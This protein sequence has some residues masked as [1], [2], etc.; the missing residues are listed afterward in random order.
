VEAGIVTDN[1]VG[2]NGEPIAGETLYNHGLVDLLEHAIGQVK[3]GEV[4]GIAIITV[5]GDPNTYYGIDVS[6]EGPQ[7]MLLS[8][9]SRL[10]FRLN[11]QLD[12]ENRPQANG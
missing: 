8:G 12:D 7:L 4:I 9:C 1:V 5:T 6:W 10:S 11:Q 3:R 2:I